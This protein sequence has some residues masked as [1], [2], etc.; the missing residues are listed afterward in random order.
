MGE[1]LLHGNYFGHVGNRIEC[2]QAVMSEVSHSCSQRL[3]EHAHERAFFSTLVSGS[4]FEEID[5]Q[6]FEYRPFETGFHPSHMPHHDGIG[7]RG[8]HF[9][10]LEITP[11]TAR[12][13]GPELA[14]KPILLREELAV[15]MARAYRAVVDKSFSPLCLESVLWELVGAVSLLGT[16]ADR[17]MPKWLAHCVDLIRSDYTQMLTI[18]DMALC[19]GVHPVHLSREFRRRF[20]QTVGE[21]THQVRIRFAC[22]ELITDNKTLAQIAM[23]CGFSDH[24]HFCR[25]FKQLI[26][27]SPSQ[28]RTSHH[29]HSELAAYSKKTR[30]CATQ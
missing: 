27:C 24:S 21:Y 15:P 25:V 6:R 19:V 8:A 17:K 10:C 28:F 26:G 16:I 23:D 3:P 13:L 20:G 1:Q 29:I 14:M 4:Y 30:P 7:V 2:E 9:L 18:Q 5:G 12:M 11:Q 22:S